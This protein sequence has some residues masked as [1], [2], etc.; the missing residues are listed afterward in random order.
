MYWFQNNIQFPALLRCLMYFSFRNCSRLL[1]L[2]R[3]LFSGSILNSHV[4]PF[5]CQLYERLIEIIELFFA[6]SWNLSAMNVPLLRFTALTY[7]EFKGCLREMLRRTWHLSVLLFLV[8]WILQLLRQFRHFILI[9]LIYV[10][11]IF[12][13]ETLQWRN[14]WLVGVDV[15]IVI[16]N[17]FFFL[18]DVILHHVNQHFKIF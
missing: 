3:T 10:S 14:S 2:F 13:H 5:R 4:V 17:P 7:F 6:S 9:I 11:F 16:L 8:P 12:H 1:F 15:R 18:W